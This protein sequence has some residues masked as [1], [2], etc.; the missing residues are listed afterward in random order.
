[1]S[2]SN[3]YYTDKT[4]K[5]SEMRSSSAHD[6]SQTGIRKTGRKSRTKR[7]QSYFDRLLKESEKLEAESE[8]E[9]Q[10]KDWDKA[11]LDSE[12]EKLQMKLNRYKD[13]YQSEKEARS[14][15]QT[16]NSWLESNFKTMK[17]AIDQAQ[18]E[19]SRN[20]V[21]KCERDDAIEKLNVLT[22]LYNAVYAR[23]LQ[24]SGETENLK[25]EVTTLQTE[26][27]TLLNMLADRDCELEEACT[28]MKYALWRVKVS[29]R[30][31]KDHTLY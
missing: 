29:D 24:S 1:M 15:L 6:A 13:G 4:N 14:R 17:K 26:K 27:D 30:S 22:R 23:H 18:L 8:K 9:K 31:S 10:A 5:I 19:R 3:P 7:L 12:K 16:R 11:R 2:L 21:N 20:E 28:H 25:V